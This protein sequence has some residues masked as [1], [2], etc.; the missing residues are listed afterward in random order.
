MPYASL[1]YVWAAKS[2][3]ETI[4][5]SPRTSRVK[6]IVVNSGSKELGVWQ[7]HH[8]DLE[9]DYEAAFSE[10]PGKIIGLGLLTDTDNTRTQVKAIYGDI[11][12]KN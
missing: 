7:K 9:K 5:T 1:M 4:I 3:I 12:L 11:E 8:R 2:P 10:K 6:M